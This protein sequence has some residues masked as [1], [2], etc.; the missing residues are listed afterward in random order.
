MPIRTL[1]L[2]VAA[3]L[4]ASCVSDEPV[5]LEGFDTATITI[6]ERELTVAV[7]E[8]PDQRSQ[9]LMGVTDLGGLDGMLF[10]FQAESNGGFWMKDTLIPL[11]IAFFDSD[12]GLVNLLT[13]EPCTADPCPSYRP[14]GSYRSAVEAPAGDLGFVVP[15]SR[16]VIAE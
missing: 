9:G 4:A 14:G 3:L 5:G 11:D 16:L 7:A 1:L 6:D 15:G 2:L 10:V 8:T 12:G 13:M